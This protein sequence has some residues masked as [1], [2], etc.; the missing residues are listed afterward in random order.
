MKK[1]VNQII[2]E[3]IIKLDNGFY[4]NNLKECAEQCR[5]LIESKNSP[6]T[7]FLINQIL[8]DIA[9]MC[10]LH[11][12]PTEQLLNVEKIMKPTIL[13]LLGDLESSSNLDQIRKDSDQ[14]V[15]NF[16]SI[17]M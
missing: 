16:V 11:P 3:M 8:F 6:S 9:D 13:R 2:H 4:I 10:D 14:M 17:K 12:L 15:I 5:T 7:L 1:D